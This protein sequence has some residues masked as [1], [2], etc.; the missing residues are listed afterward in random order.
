DGTPRFANPAFLDL[1]GYASVDELAVAGGL[2]RLFGE[3][4][5]AEQGDRKLRL[6]TKD[7]AERPVAARLQTIDWQGSHALLL[8]LAPDEPQGEQGVGEARLHH[9]QETER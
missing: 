1:S 9:G 7:G 8:T 4:D 3:P 2:E 5:A 6:V